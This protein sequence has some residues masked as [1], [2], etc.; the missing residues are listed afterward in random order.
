[1]RKRFVSSHYYRELYQKLQS[2]SQDT[3]SVDEYLKEMKLDM[4][5][6]KSGRILWLDS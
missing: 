2:L 1:M 5:R 3:K 4:I 6:A